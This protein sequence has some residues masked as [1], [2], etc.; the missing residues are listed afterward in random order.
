MGNAPD[1]GDKIHKEFYPDRYYN[2]D[3]EWADGMV[4]LGKTDHGEILN[5]NRRAVESDLVIYLNINLV[6][7]DGG[8]K[9]VAVG[10]VRL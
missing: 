1:G 3:A 2:H 7:M 10:F 8:H 6:P 5:I 9:S 4:S